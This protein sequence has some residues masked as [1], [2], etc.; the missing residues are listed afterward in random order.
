MRSTV[1]RVLAV[2]VI[3]KKEEETGF[4][5]SLFAGHVSEWNARHWLVCLLFYINM[6]KS[7]SPDGVIDVKLPGCISTKL[8]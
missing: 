1:E 7:C 8:V 6:L 3:Y 2:M 5:R 4:R